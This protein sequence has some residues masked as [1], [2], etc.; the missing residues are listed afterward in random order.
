M[1]YCV[2]AKIESLFAQTDAI[3]RAVAIAQQRAD[4]IDQAI[5]ARALG[6]SYRGSDMANEEQSGHA[7]CR[8]EPIERRR[9]RSRRP[10]HG[11]RSH[12]ALVCPTQRAS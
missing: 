9:R 8:H 4:E 11:C 1:G 12:N 6:E 3:E 5:F 10:P 7:T 2:V